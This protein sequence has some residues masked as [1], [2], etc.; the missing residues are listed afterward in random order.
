MIDFPPQ[1]DLTT[2]NILISGLIQAALVSGSGLKVLNLGRLA[3]NF[4]N[5]GERKKKNML[6]GPFLGAES[7]EHGMI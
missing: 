2:F 6:S 3:N 1:P 5:F 4:D 7:C